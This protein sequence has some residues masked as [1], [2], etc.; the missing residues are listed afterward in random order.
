[1]TAHVYP[2]ATRRE[3]E[4]RLEQLQADLYALDTKAELQ[5]LAERQAH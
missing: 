4:A 2:L 3:V 5:R 1:M